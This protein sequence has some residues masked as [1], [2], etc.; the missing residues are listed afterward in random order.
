MSAVTGQALP[1]YSSR[2]AC[3][4]AWPASHVNATAMYRFYVFEDLLIHT[5]PYGFL[6][7]SYVGLCWLAESRF[8]AQDYGFWV[9]RVLSFHGSG[10]DECFRLSDVVIHRWA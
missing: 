8:G 7:P 3:F 2:D 4:L 6:K 5:P 10:I 9:A 1:S